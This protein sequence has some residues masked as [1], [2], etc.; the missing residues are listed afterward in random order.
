MT[1]DQIKEFSDSLKEINKSN[2]GEGYIE[3][4]ELY[5][6]GEASQHNSLL[7]EIISKL[8]VEKYASF[9]Y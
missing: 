5:F 6:H 8:G 1:Q 7:S 9:M 4:S 3:E 2:H